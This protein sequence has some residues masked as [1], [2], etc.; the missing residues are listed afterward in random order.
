MEKLADKF[1]IENYKEFAQST[2][3]TIRKLLKTIIRGSPR[4]MVIE[5]L[6]ELKIIKEDLNLK[7]DK[8]ELMER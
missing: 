5:V 2:E 3:K 8:L 1:N 7:T 6:K 4:E